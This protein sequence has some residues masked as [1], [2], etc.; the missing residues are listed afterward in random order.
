MLGFFEHQYY[1]YNMTTIS[2]PVYSQ[3][4]PFQ[5]L[6]PGQYAHTVTLEKTKSSVMFI[7]PGMRFQRD[8]RKA[9]QFSLAGIV[10]RDGGESISFPFPLCTWFYR[11]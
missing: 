9:F 11:F 1:E 7:M 2:D 6:V 8:E 5:L 4:S 3:S 10:V